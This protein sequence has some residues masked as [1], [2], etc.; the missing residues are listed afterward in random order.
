MPKHHKGPGHQPPSS[1]NAQAD[2]TV[3]R[4]LTGGLR[5]YPGTLVISNGKKNVVIRNLTTQQAD[6][7]FP[8]G[9]QGTVAS[10]AALV[11]AGKPPHVL[12]DV[13]DV[14][15]IVSKYDVTQ[16]NEHAEGNSAPTL[17]IDD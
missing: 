8:K 1:S 15:D 10:K 6:V 11:G 5:V 13:S 3:Y 2:V 17:I 7:T 9:N 14:S 16:G 4:D 12:F